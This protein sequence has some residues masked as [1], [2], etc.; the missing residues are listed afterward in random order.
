MSTF[1]DDVERCFGGRDLYAALG[2]GKEAKD[3][4]L[5]RAYHRLSLQVHPDRVA[6]R[7]VEEATQKF[8]VLYF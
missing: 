3:T 7:E 4:E 8:Q 6:P 1:L 2:V 5:K